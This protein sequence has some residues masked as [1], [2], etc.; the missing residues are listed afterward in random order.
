MV[1]VCLLCHRICFNVLHIVISC[2]RMQFKEL[3]TWSTTKNQQ[4]QSWSSF[5][6][7]NIWRHHPLLTFDQ[8]WTFSM[9][10]SSWILVPYGN[11]HRIMFVAK[12]LAPLQNCFH[13]FLRVPWVP[14]QVATP[15]AGL[16]AKRDQSLQLRLQWPTS[17][18]WNETEKGDP[19]FLGSIMEDFF[20]A[21]RPSQFTIIA[22]GHFLKKHWL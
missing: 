15:L 11:H 17:Q 22:I 9:H 5:A 12:W 3:E 4:P 13:L 10:M 19:H 2:I 8:G 14:L 7:C 20:R 1:T 6:S 18:E 21:G 16:L